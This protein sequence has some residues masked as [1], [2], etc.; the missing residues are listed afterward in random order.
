[1]RIY[2]SRAISN[3]GALVCVQLHRGAQGL[4]VEVVVTCSSWLPMSVAFSPVQRIISM[5]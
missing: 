5:L 3:A 4:V 1:V 2:F